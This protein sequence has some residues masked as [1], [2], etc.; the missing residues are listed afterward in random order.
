MLS[1]VL[2]LRRAQ[3]AIEQ[4]KYDSLTPEEQEN[5][6]LPL[7]PLK[8]IIMSA[9]M[10][11]NDFQNPRLFPERM[12]PIIKVEARQ[13][14]VTVHFSKR[15]ETVNYLKETHKKVCQ[16]HKK[17]P[18]GGVLVFLSGKQ[19]ILYMCHK[20]AKSLNKKQRVTATVGV[21]VTGVSGDKNSDNSVNNG[22]I[23]PSI[24]VAGLGASAEEL[25]EQ[26][27]GPDI[28]AL[29]NSTNN[30]KHSGKNKSNSKSSNNSNTSNGSNEGEYKRTMRDILNQDEIDTDSDNED[31]VVDSDDEDADSSD[32]DGEGLAMDTT[33][34]DGTT[35]EPSEEDIFILDGDENAKKR[36]KSATSGSAINNST[37]V[38]RINSSKSALV[39][40]DSVRDQLLKEALGIDPTAIASTTATEDNDRVSSS[41]A[42][43]AAASAEKEDEEGEA[44]PELRAYILPLYA[45]MP[46]AQQNRVF[47]PVPPG[48]Q[49]FF[50]IFCELLFFTT[51]F[52]YQITLS[53]M[54]IISYSAGHRLIV[55]ATNV[56]ETSITI[57]GIR[58]V[59]DSGRQ[60]EKVM[61][62][63]TKVWIGLFVCVICVQKFVF[64]YLPFANEGCFLGRF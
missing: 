10:R 35:T 25:M 63:V 1:K 56:A 24:D 15:T 50:K 52:Y 48:K 26:Q 28:T 53:T 62:S 6:T 46:A 18:E 54:H 47:L 36:S 61:T 22:A 57:P 64:C 37:L 30:T 3:A 4:K 27:E 23:D 45:L 39:T 55:V 20:L 14:P 12:P 13:Y 59:V 21:E 8:L 60:K 43:N 42:A 19:E 31:D 7:Q 58:Y 49:F 38:S 40:G 17:L 29:L 34:G 9:T 11:V 2:P 32:S 41:D 44:V 51:L 33:G 5:C 16:I